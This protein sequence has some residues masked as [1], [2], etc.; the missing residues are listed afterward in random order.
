MTR[1]DDDHLAT[2]QLPEIV[3]SDRGT[4]LEYP[5]ELSVGKL[6]IGAGTPRPVSTIAEPSRDSRESSPA[7]NRWSRPFQNNPIPYMTRYLRAATF[8]CPV[9]ITFFVSTRFTG[10]LGTLTILTYTQ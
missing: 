3:N 6:E 10:A 5:R 1:R 9:I 2:R 8:P 4:F 7:W